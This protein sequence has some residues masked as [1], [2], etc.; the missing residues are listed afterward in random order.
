MSKKKI[1]G[2]DVL[3]NCLLKEG[4]QYIFGIT[5]GELLRI[6]DAI[7]RFGRD[8]GINTVMVRHEQNGAH[9]A[10]AYARAAGEISACMGTVGPGVM[11][12]VPGVASAY[13]DSIPM[14]V[15]GAQVGKMF[16]NTG[17]IQ[18]CIDQIGVMKPITKLQI[19]VEEPDEIPGAIQKAMKI[20]LSGKQGPVYVE[21]RETALVR[22]ASEEVLKKIKD[23]SQY[24]QE[25]R[26][27]ANEQD[28]KTIV[29]LL[30]DAKKPLIVAGG[31]VITSEASEE[32]VKL[33]TNYKIPSG[34]SINGVGSISKNE[35][36]YV[37]SM[38]TV[39]SFRT[40]ASNADIVLSFG[41]KWDYTVLFG[42]APLWNTN[43]KVIQ[44]NIDENEIGKN[45][46]AEI[47]I[48]A[49]PKSVLNQLLMEMEKSLP[50]EKITEWT[51]WNDY[52]QDFGKAEVKNIEKLM[53]SEK[54]P[55]RPQRLVLEIYDFFP[56]DTIFVIDGGDIMAF[57]HS[58]VSYCSRYPRSYLYPTAM[59][60][61]GVGIPYA[62]GAKLAKPDNPVVTITGDGAF[63]FSAQE[64]DTA[65]RLELPIIIIISNNSCWGMIKGNQQMNYEKRYCDTDLPPMDFTKIAQ[66]YGCH[67]ERV[68]NPQDLKLAFQRALDANKPAVIDVETAF[69]VTAARKLFDLYKKS[70]G[71]Y[72]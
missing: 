69:E 70:K 40:A 67:A 39:N 9:A 62:I 27:K 56:P 37:G 19:R 71:I 30:K 44:V 22:T 24:R 11:H 47:G 8:E 60:H 54:T 26:S 35:D 46:P 4:I 20:A 65:V 10:D 63:L 53:K 52:L 21:F 41:C 17:I 38:L 45:R 55:I 3:I 31:G 64:L 1:D 23:P 72:G 25:I 14:L 16:D 5:G 7:Y 48:V 34:T 36:T 59:G 2:G 43:Q 32:L 42:D 29:E 66:S 58:H 13:A 61:L 68:V 28:I 33:S 49:D 12:L 15:I 6:Y 18:G 57:C 51:E 50:K